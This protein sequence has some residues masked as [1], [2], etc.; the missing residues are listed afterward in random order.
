MKVFLSLSLLFYF[1]GTN[2]QAEAL[3]DILGNEILGVKLL[4]KALNGAR[5][6]SSQSNPIGMMIDAFD[7]LK[8]TLTLKKPNSTSWVDLEE[9]GNTAIH[10]FFF[11]FFFFYYRRYKL[12]R[13]KPNLG[14]CIVIEI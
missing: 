3:G 7:E 13:P 5:H 14:S 11:F 12:R 2:S 8:I 10:V 9:T 4:G 1:V 6:V